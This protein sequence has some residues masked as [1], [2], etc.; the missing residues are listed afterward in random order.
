[1]EYMKKLRYKTLELYGEFYK[2]YTKIK[3]F[4]VR[5]NGSCKSR[6]DSYSTSRIYKCF[7]EGL[8]EQKHIDNLDW[9]KEPKSLT[10]CLCET[11]MRFKWIRDLDY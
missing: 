2:L 4:G 3:G 5:E 10:K 9:V 8:R 11:E 6:I 1:M 7:V